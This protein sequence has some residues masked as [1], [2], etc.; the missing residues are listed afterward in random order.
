MGAIDVAD[1]YDGK[2]V[3]ISGKIITK[4]YVERGPTAIFKVE[5]IL[6]DP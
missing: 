3:T 2:E 6:L 1:S 5:S 4:D